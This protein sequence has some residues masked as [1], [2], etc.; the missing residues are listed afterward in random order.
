MKKLYKKISRL[1]S[2]EDFDDLSLDKEELWYLANI[3]PRF[4]DTKK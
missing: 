3:A 1:N 2:K 4:L